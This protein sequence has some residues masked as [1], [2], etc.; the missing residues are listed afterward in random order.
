M[1]LL[2][3]LMPTIAVCSTLAAFTLIAKRPL[4]VAIAFPA[5]E[6][7]HQLLSVLTYVSFLLAHFGRWISYDFST[8]S[9]LD[10]DCVEGSTV[11]Q[12]PEGLLRRRRN[13]VTRHTDHLFSRL[14]E[15]NFQVANSE[16]NAGAA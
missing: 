15:R 10:D 7:F 9:Q 5:L 11:V 16:G 6:I 13:L 3:Q 12:T 2:W 4:T 8:A 1:T 14:Y